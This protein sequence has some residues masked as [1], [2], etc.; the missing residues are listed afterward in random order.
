MSRFSLNQ[1]PAEPG[2][3][4]LYHHDRC[5]F[6][7]CAEDLRRRA[8][9]NLAGQGPPEA[10]GMPPGAVRMDEVTE[11]CWWL[12]PAFADEAR[13]EAAWELAIQALA[14][15]TR[16]RFSLSPAAQA[17]LADHAFAREMGKL[18]S[19]TPSG[20]FVPQT[21]DALARAIMNLEEKVG[22]LEKK[23]AERG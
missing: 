12:H 23:L 22:E 8:E 5:L 14:P 6:V 20:A 18:F 19:G 16:P 7:G 4:A 9:H 1:I 11:I 10:S 21:L 17:A 2:V 3:Y 13:R 15:A